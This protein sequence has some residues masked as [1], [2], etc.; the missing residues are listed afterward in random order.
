MCIG[1]GGWTPLKITRQENDY[2]ALNYSVNNDKMDQ[3]K[4]N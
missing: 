2:N 1:L 3:A 4:I